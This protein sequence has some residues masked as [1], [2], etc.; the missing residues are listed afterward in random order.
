[1]TEVKETS[2]PAHHIDYKD[3]MRLKAN[4]N[5]HARMFNRRRTHMTAKAQRNFASAVKRARFMALMPYIQH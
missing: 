3:I 5:P 2:Q 4:V 1:M